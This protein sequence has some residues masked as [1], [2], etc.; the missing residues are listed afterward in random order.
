MVEILVLSLKIKHSVNPES[1]IWQQ[2]ILG[3]D[4]ND[5]F[6][7]CQ[8]YDRPSGPRKYN[9]ALR[10]FQNVINENNFLCFLQIDGGDPENPVRFSFQNL[11][12]HHTFQV[13]GNF[14]DV[15]CVLMNTD[16]RIP[17][18]WTCQ[19]GGEEKSDFASGQQ[20]LQVQC[21]RFLRTVWTGSFANTLGCRY[22]Y[23]TDTETPLRDSL[24]V[25]ILSVLFDPRG[26]C[27]RT[28]KKSDSL[29]AQTEVSVSA[30]VQKVVKS[31]ELIQS[32]LLSNQVKQEEGPDVFDD[33]DDGEPMD[34]EDEEDWTFSPISKRLDVILS[35]H[36]YFLKF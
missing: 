35:V 9:I 8:I 36:I 12:I 25:E 31:R 6:H 34:Q 18:G 23:C 33:D 26:L 1:N 16:S 5:A 30:L 27:N 24:N 22:P 2:L 21:V 14:V 10:L 29:N 3:S 20:A 32:F 4:S 11:V 7:W 17:L 28:Q 15:N 13:S 19:L